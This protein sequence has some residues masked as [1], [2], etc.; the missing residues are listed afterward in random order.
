MPTDVFCEKGFFYNI[1]MF[2]VYTYFGKVRHKEGLGG[3]WCGESTA[4]G[5]VGWSTA[6]PAGGAGDEVW[7]LVCGVGWLDLGK[8]LSL[9]A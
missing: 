4:G 6:P 9:H 7:E 2:N 1:K 8:E 5:G 3:N